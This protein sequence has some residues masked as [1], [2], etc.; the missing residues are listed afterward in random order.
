[1]HE[2]RIEH[3][4]APPRKPPRR[5]GRDEPPQFTLGGLFAFFTAV[6]VCISLAATGA[7]VIEDALDLAQVLFGLAAVVTWIV[8]YVTYRKLRLR[9]ALQFH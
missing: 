9:A 4:G 2:R 7:R 6:T 3:E 1:L 5:R 8:L